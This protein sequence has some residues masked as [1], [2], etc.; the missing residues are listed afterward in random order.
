MKVLFIATL[1]ATAVFSW[2]FIFAPVNSMGPWQL[3]FPGD[4]NYDR[5]R[6]SHFTIS[7]ESSWVCPAAYPGAQHCRV[8][9]MRDTNSMFFSDEGTGPNITE[10]YKIYADMPISLTQYFAYTFGFT[11]VVGLLLVLF[12]RKVILYVA[13]GNAPVREPAI[14]EMDA[15]LA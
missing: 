7:D 3:A 13:L 4:A 10:K 6:T 15:P 12:Y 11:A 1:V 2:I 8:T 9:Y 5:A 14:D